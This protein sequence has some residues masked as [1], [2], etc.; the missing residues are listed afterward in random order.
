[1]GGKRAFA[2]VK[3]DPARGPCAAACSAKHNRLDR[4]TTD[5]TPTLD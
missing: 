2:G 3:I 5:T 4:A 1:M